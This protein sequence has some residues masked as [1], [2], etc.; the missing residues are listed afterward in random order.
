MLSN[1]DSFDNI[2]QVS[3]YWWEF[4]LLD[5]D[6]TV[7]LGKQDLNTEF[8]FI[9]TAADFIQSTFGLSP[10]TAFPTY[11]DQSMAAVVLLQLTDSWRLKTGVWN[12]F[13]KG[14]SWGFSGDDSLLVVG[15]LECSFALSGGSL[16]GIF[17]VGA[18]YES[19]GTI[20]GAGVPP[21]H[22][23]IFQIEQAI[24]RECPGDN[25]NHQGLALFGAY[26]PRFP[27]DQ[28]VDESIGDSFVAGFTYTGLFRGRDEDVMGVGVAY[29]ELFRGVTNQET[30]TELFY[31]AQLTPRVSLQPDLQYISSP[32]GIYRDAF[33]AG[34]RFQW[35]L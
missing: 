14:G 25:D 20:D 5:E 33:V 24:Y 27:G 26:Y 28:I 3:E 1:I 12:A 13:A 30:V 10:S 29:A 9:D 19:G 7:R 8:L 32:S 21:V 34:V 22:E 15:E 35:T 17:A 18:V 2:M 23:Y 11:P 16:P 4:N 31:K 6:C